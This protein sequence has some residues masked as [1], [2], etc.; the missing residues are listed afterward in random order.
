MIPFLLACHEPTPPPVVQRPSVLVILWDTVRADRLSLHGHTAP[1]TPNLDR[2]AAGGQ[3]FERAISPGFW[4]LPAHASLFTG[5][6][7]TAHGATWSTPWLD[8]DFVTMAEWFSE[9]G[10]ATYAWST[11][12]NIHPMRNTT[13]GFSTYHSPFG[14]EG[15][16][17]RAP[18]LSATTAR[19]DPADASTPSSPA[20]PGKR[21]IAPTIAGPVAPEAFI[22]WLTEVRPPDQPY[23][24][25]INLM[26]THD[27]R[28][29]T[30]E[31][32]AAMLGERAA[33]SLVLNASPGRMRRVT[34]GAETYTEPQR[35]V[36]RSV[37][38]ATLVDLDASTGRLLDALSAIGALDD[39]IVVITSDH[40]EALGEHG[41][42]RHNR[43]LYDSLVHVPLVL[44]YPPAVSPGRTAAPVSTASVFATIASLAG[45]PLPETPQM[46][47]SSLLSAPA[48]AVFSECLE[49][50][51]TPKPNEPPSM[52]RQGRT[53]VIGG[54]KLIRYSDDVIELFHTTV[55]PGEQN[56]LAATQ[57]ERVAKMSA[58]LASWVAGLTPHT[59]VVPSS[60]QR[61]EADGL[62]RES[63]LVED[64]LEALEALG[65]VE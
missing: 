13:Q 7:V 11:N 29:P 19:M 50:V 22:D 24:A 39:T 5:L 27:P 35:E 38:D 55:D 47:R 37:F 12:P 8:D 18:V 48:E 45:L 21:K 57:P 54:W 61:L 59:P 30:A 1:T 25:F 32:R 40:G 17:W 63:T 36:L 46:L 31:V 52:W 23:W 20:W 33:A 56:N 4:T 14:E 10:Y 6:P 49:P 16:P 2:F 65:Y 62:Y 44:H 3:V 26:E 51:G 53:V 28:L 15:N 42:Y 60:L 34:A 43:G 9:H 64:V 41:L 58:V